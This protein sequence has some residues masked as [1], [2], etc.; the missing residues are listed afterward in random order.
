VEATAAT[1]PQLQGFTAYPTSLFLGRDGRIR[2]VHAGFV[3]PAAGAQHA[4]HVAELRTTIE[5]LLREP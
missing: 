2:E 5:R 4:R 1:L 3:G